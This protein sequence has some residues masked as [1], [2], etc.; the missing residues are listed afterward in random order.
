VWTVWWPRDRVGA[1]QGVRF[2]ILRWFHALTWLLLAIAAFLAGLNP[3]ASG[4]A[5]LIAFCG[6]IVYL[7][8]MATL[9]T[10]RR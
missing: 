9:V 3:V 1:A 10:S 4:A 7:V 8:F 2:V 6:L 5:R